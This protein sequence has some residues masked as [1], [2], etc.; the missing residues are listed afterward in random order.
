M[1]LRDEGRLS[2][3]DTLDTLRPRGHPAGTDDPAVPEPTSRACSASRSATCGRRWSTPTR[4]ELVAASTQAERVHRAA[5][6]L[7][8]LQPGLLDAR[9]GRRPARRAALGRVAAGPDPR[10]AGDAAHDGRLRRPARAGLLRPAVD[11]RAGARSTQLDLRAMDPC[12]GLASTGADLARWSAF[13]ADPVDEVL[14]PDT[15]EEMCRAADHDGPRALDRRHGSR[16]L[17]GPLRH[18]H[19]RR[20]HRRHARTHHGRLHRPERQHRRA[21]C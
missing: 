21:S 2:L 17:P 11:R 5:P 1:Q 20:P 4:A 19:V 10:S 14:A 9:R 8:L 16:L 13:V 3:D 12:G 15:L 18:P 7:A 6:A